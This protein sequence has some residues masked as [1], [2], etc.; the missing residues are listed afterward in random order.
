MSQQGVTTGSNVVHFCFSR[1]AM[2]CAGVEYAHHIFGTFHGCTVAVYVICPPG[3]HS[4]LPFWYSD[5]YDLNKSPQKCSS[6][7]P[8]AHLLAMIFWKKHFYSRLLL[9]EAQSPAT[10]QDGLLSMSYP[11]VFSFY[12]FTLCAQLVKVPPSIDNINSLILGCA[13]AGPRDS[14]EYPLLGGGEK[15]VWP[16]WLQRG[17]PL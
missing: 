7:I 9:G 17:S 10:L 12:D 13:A 8:V 6:F 4:F 5:R 1:S 16:W 11:E 3:K 15:L 2:E 14:A